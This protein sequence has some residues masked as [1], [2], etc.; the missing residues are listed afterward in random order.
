MPQAYTYSFQ[1]PFNYLQIRKFEKFLN[2][3]LPS[4][5]RGVARNFHE[6]G[7]N[8]KI[9]TTVSFPNVFT[10]PF[11]FFNMVRLSL[12][13]DFEVALQ[14]A[15]NT[16][17]AGGKRFDNSSKWMGRYGTSSS[18][19]SHDSCF[20][21]TTAVCDDRTQWNKLNAEES[22][23]CLTKSCT[24]ITEFELIK[25]IPRSSTSSETSSTGDP[26]FVKTYK[27]EYFR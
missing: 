3:I 7:A 23:Y 2:F 8:F 5:I 26:A 4:K 17:F 6:V 22:F 15:V 25:D 10:L 14:A 1:T 20:Q 12:F 24:G 19:S 18:S 21:G 9:N 11:F 16:A 13:F 27:K